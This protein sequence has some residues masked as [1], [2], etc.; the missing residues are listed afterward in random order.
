MIRRV[1]LAVAILSLIVFSGLVV[2][3]NSTYSSKTPTFSS[4][5]TGLYLAGYGWGTCQCGSAIPGDVNALY[6]VTIQ[7]NNPGKIYGIEEQINLTGTDMVNS[8]VTD[9][10]LASSVV[11][12][13]LG[14]GDTGTAT[15]SISVLQESYMQY[16][17]VPI[18]ISYSNATGQG[19]EFN[20][21]LTF[22]IA[23]TTPLQLSF[24]GSSWTTS[25]GNPGGFQGD[26]NDTLSLKFENPNPFAVTD[27]SSTLYLPNSTIISGNEGAEATDFSASP[28]TVP[29]GGTGTLSFSLNIAYGAPV[30]L[31]STSISVSYQDNDGAALNTSLTLPDSACPTCISI[32]AAPAVSISQL[33]TAVQI[34]GTST[35]TLRV[36][37][38]G[39]AAIFSP[40]VDL[41]LPSGLLVT[42]NFTQPS[43]IPSIA[44]QSSALFYYN[45]TA[46]SG[47]TLGKFTGSATINYI[48]QFGTPKSAS[49]P[50]AI[51]V[52][53]TIDLAVQAVKVAQSLQSVKVS[54]TLINYGDGSASLAQVYVY[55]NK[56]GSN[57]VLGNASLYIGDIG[58]ISSIPFTGIPIDY[59]APPS[60]VPATVTLV[61]IYVNSTDATQE[62]R[63]T[64]SVLLLSAAS[65][66]SPGYSMP[67]L[68]QNVVYISA[69]VL[70]VIVVS[71]A[72]FLYLRSRR[73]IKEQG[74][75]LSQT[76]ETERSSGSP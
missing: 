55:L 71:V 33:T 68:S 74:N 3:L 8:T 18:F 58:A 27:L 40:S 41:S 17:D 54:G 19:G 21:T 61:L 48:N 70:V 57:T 44:A 72:S 59:F 15:F 4:A 53:G 66:E 67:H 7:N 22:D 11:S 32:Y 2:E 28:S 65:F 29:S 75:N 51:D 13:Q 5:Y 1:F 34:Q 39:D 10:T 69:I 31:V 49:F 6:S 52:V 36:N 47:A 25:K 14:P 76:P 24:I 23:I 45:V 35:F 62:F 20:Q 42:G 12:G 26:Q 63:N 73:Q 46:S 60:A 64:T 30:G 43:S 38:V 9:G 56:T 50:L 16:Y 37:N